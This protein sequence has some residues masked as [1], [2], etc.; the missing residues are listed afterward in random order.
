MAAKCTY[1]KKSR[2]T[3]FLFFFS[4]V[5]EK[6]KLVLFYASKGASRKVQGQITVLW[7][8][9]A[10]YFLISRMYLVLLVNIP[11]FLDSTICLCILTSVILKRH[12]KILF[13]TFFRRVYHN[14]L[15][16]KLGLFH[17]WSQIV[18]RL[19]LKSQSELLVLN[20]V[21]TCTFGFC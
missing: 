5:G 15:K 16:G 20:Y 13:S 9:D 4:I 21:S 3:F 12:G 8:A 18:L 1:K 6:G 19:L 14:C 2:A 11:H 10:I 7:K 17:V